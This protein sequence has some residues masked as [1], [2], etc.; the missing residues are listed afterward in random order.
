MGYLYILF[1]HKTNNMDSFILQNFSI[2]FSV[3]GKGLCPVEHKQLIRLMEQVEKK[4]PVL[5]RVTKHE[6]LGIYGFHVGEEKENLWIELPKVLNPVQ[7]KTLRK[8]DTYESDIDNLCTDLSKILTQIKLFQLYHY[9]QRIGR[10][11]TSEV[12]WKFWQWEINY[13]RGTVRDPLQPPSGQHNLQDG[14]QMVQVGRSSGEKLFVPKTMYM[15]IVNSFEDG[16]INLR[17]QGD[18]IAPGG[19]IPDRTILRFYK[20]QVDCKPPR[21]H[22]EKFIFLSGN[23]FEQDELWP[24]TAPY[25]CRSRMFEYTE[26]G[27]FVKA[28]FLNDTK[29]S[30]PDF[31]NF[32]W[33]ILCIPQVLLDEA[34]VVKVDDT[35]TCFKSLGG[36]S[37]SSSSGYF[38]QFS[39]FGSNELVKE[40]DLLT[41]LESLGMKE[42]HENFLEECIHTLEDAKSLSV[43]DLK[44]I[45]I[46]T[47]GDR[48]RFLRE[49]RKL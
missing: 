44:Q 2:P 15:A 21:N 11:E 38:G 13:G 17:S 1:F 49:I 5:K 19:T 18:K 12:Y 36:A 40:W 30:G 9:A 45:G 43:D 34:P 33:N 27:E 42:Y 46:N 47:I 23:K 14:A 26:L 7:K 8:F 6:E 16:T 20:S 31:A 4:I 25:G 41:F 35:P 37:S 3:C 29:Y 24:M 39:T 48:N 22:F 28:V 10:A 32:K